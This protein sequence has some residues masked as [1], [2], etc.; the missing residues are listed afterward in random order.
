M[1]VVD[2]RRESRSSFAMLSDESH[3]DRR[4][5]TWAVPCKPI[6]ETCDHSTISGNRGQS[7]DRQTSRMKTTTSHRLH[8]L[9]RLSDETYRSSGRASESDQIERQVH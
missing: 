1:N 9:H 8:E 3:R 4:V 6:S 2:N 7:T 5:S